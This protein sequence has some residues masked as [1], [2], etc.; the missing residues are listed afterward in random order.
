MSHLSTLWIRFVHHV[1]STRLTV[2]WTGHYSHE[3][4][5]HSLLHADGKIHSYT[6]EYS[7]TLLRININICSPTLHTALAF[8]N[9]NA[10][11]AQYLSLQFQLSQSTSIYLL[12]YLLFELFYVFVR[13]ILLQAFPVCI[14]IAADF[15]FSKPLFNC[16]FLWCR[17]QIMFIKP[18]FGLSRIFF[19]IRQC[20]INTRNSLLYINSHDSIFWQLSSLYTYCLKVGTN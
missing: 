8:F 17:V 16:S 15:K 10:Q 9:I 19:R 11:Y 3:A 2:D 13:Y 7:E 18:S 1:Q 6:V 20:F 4:V 5:F 14:D 12:S